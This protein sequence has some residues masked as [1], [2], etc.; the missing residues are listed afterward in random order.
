MCIKKKFKFKELKDLA[1]DSSKWSK[2]LFSRC[3]DEKYPD[4]DLNI[5]IESVME[6][7]MWPHILIS[8][9]MYIVNHY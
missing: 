7:D 3:L 8:Y 6:Y 1:T 5:T 2:G 9:G 4:S